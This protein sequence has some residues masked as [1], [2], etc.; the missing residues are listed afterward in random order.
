MS[1]SHELGSR[2]PSAPPAATESRTSPSAASP[3]R[4][5]PTATRVPEARRSPDR[6]TSRTRSVSVRHAAALVPASRPPRPTRRLSTS[7]APSP[8]PSPSLSPGP[9]PHP[10]ISPRLRQRSPASSTPHLHPRPTDAV[11]RSAKDRRLPA[12][13]ASRRCRSGSPVTSSPHSRPRVPVAPT[14]SADRKPPMSWPESSGLGSRRLPGCGGVA[15]GP[16]AGCRR[17]GP[18]PGWS[19]S[20]VVPVVRFSSSPPA[21]APRPSPVRARADGPRERVRSSV[22]AVRRRVRGP[23]GRSP[24]GRCPGRERPGGSRGR[25]GR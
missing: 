25:G 8:Q 16:P 6:P 9:P 14:Y 1:K 3:S 11:P 7:H 23:P 20:S 10:S 12:S 17:H 2:R 24:P 18:V 13:L 5:A 21:F 19:G 15:V 22:T 4:E